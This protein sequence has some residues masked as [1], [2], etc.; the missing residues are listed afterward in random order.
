[1]MEDRNKI[2]AKIKS[3]EYM[4]N[5]LQTRVLIEFEAAW[6]PKWFSDLQSIASTSGPVL[7]AFT[8]KDYGVCFYGDRKL[9]LISVECY[10]IHSELDLPS[11]IALTIR[12]RTPDD[13]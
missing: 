10:D 11:E 7:S 12:A 2:H 9:L 1:V 13:G 6:S 3:V 8:Y 5:G 4:I